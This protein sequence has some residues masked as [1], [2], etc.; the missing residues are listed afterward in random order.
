MRRVIGSVMVSA[1]AV[2]LGIAGAGCGAANTVD[3]VAK[4][5]TISNQAP[6]LRMN[7]QMRL[8]TPALPTPLLVT[9]SGSFDTP[10]RS[11]SFGIS[12]D[13]SSIPQAAQVLG[14][15]SLQLQEVIDGTTIYLKLPPALARSFP[16][17]GKTWIKI[18]LARASQSL[19]VSGLSSL[20]NNPSSTDP[21]QFLR[22]LRAESGGVTRI[23]TA[24]VDGFNTT[25]YRAR[26]DLSKV[27][28]VLS[29]AERAQAGRTVAQLE[30]LTHLRYVPVKVWV[31]GQHLVRR[32]A[33]SFDETVSGQSLAA[34]MQIDFPQYGPQPP[35][36]LP[37][38]SEV[39]DLSGQL[40]AAG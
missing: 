36:Q 23:G 38:P 9:G 18:D 29:A 21:S 11:G 4:A 32:L 10:Q 3:P 5:A 31:D 12:M 22:Y 34:D 19:G 6:G 33:L 14:A 24:Q 35:P 1:A 27:G 15:S 17:H 26:I 7:L 13:L 40:P 25:E 39:A 8:S 2:L 20:L 37:P 16:A 30:Q 28:A